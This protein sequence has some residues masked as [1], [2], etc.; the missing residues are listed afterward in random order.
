MLAAINHGQLQAPVCLSAHEAL[1]ACG[2][3]VTAPPKRAPRSRAPDCRTAMPLSSLD[4]RAWPSSSN[5]DGRSALKVD[6][7]QGWPP[8]TRTCTPDCE[9]AAAFDRAVTDALA[10][11]RRVQ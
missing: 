4:V 3:A 5:K 11:A 9:A 7:G 6:T 8:R 2:A 10:D 1:R